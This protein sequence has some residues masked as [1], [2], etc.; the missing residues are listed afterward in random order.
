VVL[1][2][3]CAPGFVPALNIL[4]LDCEDGALEAVH[5]GV[6]ANLVV[7]V[8]ALHAVLAE[9]LYAIGQFI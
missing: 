8:A 3:D 9:H 7:V 5:A 4:E 2:G 1:F 6:P